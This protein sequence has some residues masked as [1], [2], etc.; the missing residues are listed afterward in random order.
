MHQ[1]R[2]QRSLGVLLGSVAKM[3][4]HPSQRAFV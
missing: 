4:Q 3:F 1:L 2:F